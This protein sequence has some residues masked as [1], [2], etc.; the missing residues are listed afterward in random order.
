MRYTSMLFFNL[1]QSNFYTNLLKAIK[2]KKV[3]FVSVAFCFS[4]CLF[5]QTDSTKKK[6]SILIMKNVK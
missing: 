1:I 6:C 4:M 3:I 2:M 5:A